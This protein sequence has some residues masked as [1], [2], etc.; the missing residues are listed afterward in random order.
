MIEG[1][2][3]ISYT[4]LAN[5]H[6]FFWVVYINL[7]ICPSELDYETRLVQKNLMCCVLP[8]MALECSG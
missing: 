4:Y 1:Y 2:D 7:G 8:C 5:L 3:Y 6:G